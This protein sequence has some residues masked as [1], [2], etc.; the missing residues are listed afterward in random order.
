MKLRVLDDSLRLRLSRAEVDLLASDGAV[1]AATRFPGGGELAYR[2]EAGDGFAASEDAGVVTITVP[3][4]EVAAWASDET[5]VGLYARLDNGAGMLQ[6]IVEKDFHC[7][8]PRPGID[9]AD[10]FPNPKTP[11]AILDGR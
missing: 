6:V 3:D 7:L 4:D 10:F 8:I 1:E 11:R 2:L 9:P 5:Q